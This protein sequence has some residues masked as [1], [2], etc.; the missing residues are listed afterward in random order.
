[1][2]S[3][4]DL[5]RPAWLLDDLPSLTEPANDDDI[6]RSR[7]LLSEVLAWFHAYEEWIAEAVGLDYRRETLVSWKPKDYIVIPAEEMA[8]AWRSL[9]EATEVL[10]DGRC[11]DC[12]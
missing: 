10:V 4:A 1:L 5:P 7:R 2:T 9:V 8:P 12:Q 11:T 3:A 6:H